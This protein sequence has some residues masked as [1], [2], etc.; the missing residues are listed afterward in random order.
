M[1][2]MMM[3]ESLAWVTQEQRKPAGAPVRI[4]EQGLHRGAMEPTQKCYRSARPDAFKGP[5]ALELGNG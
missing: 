5:R 2:F 1:K 3:S 4:S